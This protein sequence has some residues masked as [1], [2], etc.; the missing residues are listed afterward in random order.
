[1]L[2][3]IRWRKSYKLHSNIALDGNAQRQHEP[4]H[5]RGGWSMMNLITTLVELV[6]DWITYTNHQINVGCWN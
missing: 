1:M 3:L 2:I 4:K 5:Q 6:Q